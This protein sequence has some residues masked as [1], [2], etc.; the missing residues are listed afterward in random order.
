MV[1]LD[2]AGNG[3]RD[4]I[5]PL[6]TQDD[7]LARAISVVAAFH[8]TRKAPH[9]RQPA[10][11]GH[12]AILERLQRDSLHLPPE[13]IFTP[14]TW[15][16]IMVLLVGETI[17]GADNYLHLLE[18]LT[19]LRQ[20]PE[21]VDAL[22]SAL[23]NF[24]C[25]QVKMFELFGFPLSSEEKGALVLQRKPDY[26]MDFMTYPT[27]PSA[28]EHLANLQI[29]R[30]A[31]C[32]ACMLYQQRTASSLATPDFTS[33]VERL[34]Q[35]VLPLEAH[36]PG[37]HALVWT[38]FVAASESILPDHRVFFSSRLREIYD[39]TGF[40]SIPAALTAL[41]TIWAMQGIKRWT[42]IA[43][44]DLPVLVM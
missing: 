1:V 43:C 33:H 3:Y 40:G 21:A 16:T 19:C 8:L 11:A 20:S 32:D 14:Y 2:I 38:Y 18:A 39:L 12:R 5:L 26:Y 30:A 4:I 23:R 15:A 28:S 42:E 41:E 37:A 25:Q 34:R 44:K 17:T 10:I 27:L 7:V 35:R 29:M 22:P 6:A 9:L 13:R 31:I 24:F 36:T